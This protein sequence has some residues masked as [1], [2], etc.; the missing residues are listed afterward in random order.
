[1]SE[2][3]S[4]KPAVAS[5]VN[6][7]ALEHDILKFWER[8][9]CF[10]RLMEKRAA[11]P[12]FRFLDGPITANNP[13][14]A[15]HAWGRTLKDIFLRYK[16]LTGHRCHYQNGFDC[17]GLWV[18]VEVEKELGFNGKPDIEAFGLDKFSKACRARVEKFSKI[19]IEQSIR[20]GQWMD[21]DNSYYTLTD[22]NIE[23]I[24]LFLKKCQENGWL[25]KSQLSMPWCARCGTSLSEHEMAGSYKQLSHLALYIKLKVPALGAR[26]L[27]WT[28]TPWTL[29]ANTALA[30]NPE[31]EY[32]LANFPGEELPLVLSSQVFEN[33]KT[34]GAKVLRR[35][36]G[37]ELEG[38][39]YEAVFA[40]IPVQ[41]NFEHRVV[42]WNL[43]DPSD[44]TGVVHIAPG[45]GHEDFEL[46][47]E[48]GLACLTPIDESGFFTAGYGWL[49]GKNAQAVP[50]EV[51]AYLEQKGKLWKKEM[52]A[53]SYPVCWRCKSEL[54]FRLVDE[55]YI[56]SAE[57]RPRMI[58]AASQVHWQPDY[59][60]KRMEDWLSNMGDWCISRKR[61]WGLPLPFYCCSDCGST[62]VLGS[63]EELAKLSGDNLTS[64]PELHRP[65]IDEIKINCPTCGKKVSRVTE[66]GD[67]WLDAGIVPYS[68]RGY[69]DKPEE[70]SQWYP[71]EW[72]CEMSEQVR[73]WFYSMLFMGVTLSERAPYER[74]LTYERVSAEDGSRF[75]K[76][77]KMI[78]FHEAAEVMG[79]DTMRYYFASQPP[80]SDIRFGFTIGDETRRQ[81]ISLWNIYSFF[82][83]YALIDK[84]NLSSVREREL[85]LTLIDR[86]LLARLH[87]FLE[88]TAKAYEEYNSVA[89]VREFE[90]FAEELSNWYIRQNRRRFWKASMTAD[91][92]TAYWVLFQAI[93]SISLVMGP[94]IPFITEKIWLECVRCFE[95]STEI[96]VHLGDWPKLD[97]L[98]A[99]EKVVE[100]TSYVREIITQALRLRVETQ[101]KTRQPL[102]SLFIGGKAAYLQAAQKMKEL[103]LNELNVKE[104]ILVEDRAKL[105][106]QYLEVDLAKAGR[107]LKGDLPKVIAALKSLSGRELEETLQLVRSS[108]SVSLSALSSEI[109]AELF[110]IKNKEKEGLRLLDAEGFFLALDTRITPELEEEGWVRDILR[111]CQVLRKDSG[112]DVEERIFLSLHTDSAKLSQAIEQYKES[113]E[114]ETLASLCSELPQKAQGT[115]EIALAP[116]KLRIALTPQN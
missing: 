14:G 116:G 79:V 26:I 104:L 100:E 62:T 9:H 50:E 4:D 16:A 47:K 73:L 25:Y 41:Q 74:I 36:M 13:M 28:T 115:K 71:A 83:T 94:I 43:V 12:A 34:K 33:W 91:K 80:T 6:L 32:I 107:A 45:C 109:P 65:W 96:S 59:M 19:Q 22:L 31:L 93:K 63:K 98:W 75:S 57:I 76:T 48:K 54:V 21:W 53:H 67:C 88:Q 15:H 8:E 110:V 87:R 111:H 42:L 72:I 3:V 102:A 106:E 60:L 78:Q 29:A 24:W 70:W 114:A 39:E 89:V 108:S 1:M 82:M 61:Y 44:G 97:A 101:L 30:V 99:N 46:G 49:E 35:F 64:L 85:E 105:A 112:L 37:T 103:I 27:V 55:W 56:S 90:S 66:V 20:L 58:N 52:H 2:N 23:C 5:S 11:S 10:Q 17:Q 77:G 68:T 113:I 40:D 38:L 51:A 7:I 86:W 81:L 69:K 92:L 18:E 84:P 95:P